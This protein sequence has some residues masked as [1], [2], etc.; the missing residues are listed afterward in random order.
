MMRQEYVLNILR[1]HSAL[2]VLISA[3]LIS[4]S[5]TVVAGAVPQ[6]KLDQARAVKAEI[7]ALD[8][9]VEKA[10]E[11]YNIAR[12]NY[13]AAR[14]K[15]R[16]TEARLATT[17]KRMKVVQTHLNTRANVMYRQGDAGFLEVLLGAGSF[18]DFAATWDILTN[19]N[20]QDASNVA[21]LR[22]LRIETVKLRKTLVAQ[23]KRAKANSDSMNTIYKSINSQLATRKAKLRGLEAE[24]DTLN[25]QEEA[26]RS[27]SYSSDGGG[28]GGGNFPPPTRAPRS[29]VVAIAKQY[30]GARYVWGASG[31]NTFD[32]SGF[33]MF[34]YRQ[35]GVSLPH[36]SRAQIHYG[37]RV[38][39]ADLQP[40]DLVF[41]GSPIHHVGMYVGGGMYIHAPHTGDVVK[42]SSMGRG[43]FAGAC[44][45]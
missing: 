19:L 45:P 12:I 32:C 26:A 27:A 1:K 44:R 18:D 31:P 7:D 28:S 25:R 30:L 8:M 6:S 29:E 22:K 40:G 34:V 15:R 33:T 11:K 41:F 5:L 43:D 4:F 38:S 3:L 20:E 14:N 9:R 35:V 16:T 23:E 21:E 42:I 24:I 17:K 13:L 2:T 37:E 10:A 36:S 39:R